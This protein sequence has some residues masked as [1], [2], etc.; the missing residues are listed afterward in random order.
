MFIWQ[1]PSWPFLALQNLL[2]WKNE[3]VQKVGAPDLRIYE[4]GFQ[5]EGCSLLPVLILQI[6][7]V[8]LDESVCAASLCTPHLECLFIQISCGTWNPDWCCWQSAHEVEIYA[9]R[10][11]M[12]WATIH[13]ACQRCYF[14]NYCIGVPDIENHDARSTE[15]SIWI[16]QSFWHSLPVNI[17]EGLYGR[18]P[19]PWGFKI[20]SQTERVFDWSIWLFMCAYFSGGICIWQFRVVIT[21]KV[22]CFWSRPSW[23]LAA[24]LTIYGCHNWIRPHFFWLSTLSTGTSC[25][26]NFWATISE[27]YDQI[28]LVALIFACMY[29][30]VAKSVI[31]LGANTMPCCW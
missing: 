10:I 4:H 25:Q 24:E 15:D 19:E 7:A 27:T 26:W 29:G 30:Y 11:Q 9:G 20:C 14:G 18:T 13:F 31:G 5:S 2:I 17:A 3:L 8:V 22:C 21:L 6:G 28:E 1:L 16:V 23:F 12:Q